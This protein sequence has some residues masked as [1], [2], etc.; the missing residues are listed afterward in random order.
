M[1][2][3]P[4]PKQ[5]DPHDD[6]VAALMQAYEQI[7]RDRQLPRVDKQVSRLE[8][9]PRCPRYQGRTVFF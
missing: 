7:G 3:M 6:A 2:S 4:N 1:N 8:P 9:P 5:I